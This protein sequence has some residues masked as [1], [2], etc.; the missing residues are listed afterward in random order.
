MIT[1]A[2]FPFPPIIQFFSEKLWV[3]VELAD[4]T[5]LS[6]YILNPV[7]FKL[8]NEIAMA[9]ADINSDGKADVLD[10]SMLIEY[11]LGTLKKLG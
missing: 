1:S 6:K 10:N 11:N 7:T 5:V 2:I 3:I 4:I 9:N 8:K